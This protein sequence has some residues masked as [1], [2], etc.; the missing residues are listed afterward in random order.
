MDQQK[1]RLFP[2]SEGVAPYF[3]LTNLVIPI[4]FLVQQPPNFR[5]LGFVL[6]A[7]FAV[8][9]RQYY[10]INKWG[11][12]ILI[13]QVGVLL[14]LAALFHPMFAFLGFMV[15]GPLAKQKLPIVL[16]TSIGFGIGMAVI[17]VP[18]IGNAGP[19]LW[20]GLL[21]PVFGLC[22]MPYIIRAAIKVQ[23]R[24]AQM[25]A[26][27]AERMA[28]QE[29][30]QRIAREL[31]DTLGHT[32]SLIALKGEVVEKLVVRNPD[33][34]ILEA[35]EIR[36]TARSALKQMRELVTEMKFAYFV[37]EYHHALSLC[38]AADMSLKLFYQS[39]S[40]QKPVECIERGVIA[41]IALPLNALQE[42]IM[43]MC[44]RETVTNVVRHSGAKNCKI[45]LEIQEGE[46]RV[47]VS[48]DGVGVDTDRMYTSSNGMA[49]LRQRL[50]LIDGRISLTSAIGKGTDVT[51]HIPRVIRNE[52]VGTA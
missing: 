52:K 21:I 25:R 9:F 27:T 29:E 10:F 20:I 35:R 18:Y 37:D 17:A 50:I 6:L 28:Q 40:T 22:V 41:N 19:Q 26:D 42:T 49:G 31:H 14:C 47:T 46:I 3:L 16:S 13:T 8:L 12:H 36:E 15:A 7:L 39:V 32:L 30:R 1:W 43:A 24:N 51:I 48:D 5:W 11:P 34:A 45:L 38:S 44:F 4:Y 23:Q 2:K 33:R